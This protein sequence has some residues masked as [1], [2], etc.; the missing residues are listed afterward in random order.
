MPIGF[1]VSSA[2]LAAARIEQ[3][4]V[5][6]QVRQIE[7]QIAID[8]T[9]AATNVR[10]AVQ[11]VEAA[12]AAQDLAQQTYEAEQVK[13]EVG[14]STNYNVILDLNALNTVKNSYL[15]AV[16]NYRNT[17]V[18]LDRLQQTTL[19]SLNVTLL[20]PASWNPGS[21][22]TGDLLLANGGATVGSAR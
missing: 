14:F 22:A 15:Q 1:N 4:Q 10:S 13:L 2:A 5:E 19:N 9:N 18:E 17:L 3:G 12:Q 6:L 21:A 20:S 8:V 11:A 7:L 16:L